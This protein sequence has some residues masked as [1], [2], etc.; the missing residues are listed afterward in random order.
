MSRFVLHQNPIISGFC[1]FFIVSCSWYFAKYLN[2]TP[3]LNDT[4]QCSDYDQFI[5]LELCK[6]HVYEFGN[7][8]ITFPCKPDLLT[9]LC[10]VVLCIQILPS[11]TVQCNPSIALSHS[12]SLESSHLFN[13]LI[14]L[15][16]FDT[17]IDICY[18]YFIFTICAFAL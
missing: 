8:S 1:F 5:T 11:S 6:S 14:A 13:F 4:H 7:Q 18:I 9:I 16:L 17:N 10:S 12:I 3:S 15:K 2:S